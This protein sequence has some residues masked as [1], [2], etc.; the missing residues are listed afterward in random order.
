MRSKYATYPEYHT[1]LDNMQFVTRRGLEESYVAHQRIV[2][3]LEGDCAPR[4]TVRCEPKM[5]D[6][7]L[8]PTIGKRGSADG[9]RAMMNLLAYAD[10]SSSLLDIATII[11]VP[12][13]ELRPLAEQLEALE[14]LRIES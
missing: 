11:G 9:G 10:G 4:Y 2:D 7:G 12:V 1:S 8:R 5:S 3:T 6:R 14:L 13:W